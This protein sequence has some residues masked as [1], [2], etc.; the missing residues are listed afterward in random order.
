MDWPSWS[1]VGPL[2]I[3]IVVVGGTWW[4]GMRWLLTAADTLLEAFRPMIQQ[5]A[6]EVAQ[7]LYAK[8]KEDLDALEARLREDLA[9]L[10]ERIDGRFGTTATGE[11]EEAP[12]S[13]SPSWSLARRTLL[14]RAWGGG[15]KKG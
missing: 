9:S 13:S 10:G 6:Q 2:L 14:R 4:A 1:E 8:I 7:D 15:R 12:T 5:V 11:Q 3:L